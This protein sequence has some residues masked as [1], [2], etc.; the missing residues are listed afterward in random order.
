MM[1]VDDEDTKASG[2]GGGKALVN[3]E[4]RDLIDIKPVGKLGERIIETIFGGIGHV[5]NDL[6]AVRRAEREGRA[7]IIRA[8]ADA[9]VSEIQAAS[10]GRSDV[11]VGAIDIHTVEGRARLRLEHEAIRHQE[12]IEQ[13]VRHAVAYADEQEAESRVSISDQT[14][15]VDEGWLLQFN[16]ICKKATKDEMQRLLGKVLAQ[17]VANPGKF[18]VRAVLTLTTVSVE[19]ARAFNKICQIYIPVLGCTIISDKFMFTGGEEYFGV[20]FNDIMLCRSAGL[21]AHSDRLAKN[22]NPNSE[23]ELVYADFAVRIICPEGERIPLHTIFFTT[24]GEELACIID[25]RPNM[26]F[27]RQFKEYLEGKGFSVLIPGLAEQADRP[28]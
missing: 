7:A 5:Y 26:E 20:K 22:F 4:V 23:V 6:T 12:N 28:E 3:V 27:I 9:R 1:A 13:V 8:E 25:V 24:V 19:E 10:R 17:E 18:S 16:D 15:D 21:I 11:L 2:E 14:P